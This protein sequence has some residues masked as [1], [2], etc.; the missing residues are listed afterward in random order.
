MVLSWVVCVCV[1]MCSCVLP[2]GQALVHSGKRR[3]AGVTITKG[4]RFLLVGFLD[5]PGGGGLELHFQDHS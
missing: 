4:K 1:C 3:H 5:E 2:Q